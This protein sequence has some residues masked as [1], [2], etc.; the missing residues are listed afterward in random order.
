M[1]AAIPQEIRNIKHNNS[2]NLKRLQHHSCIFKIR[3]A[4]P[5]YQDLHVTLRE[6]LHW[7]LRFIQFV[8][9]GR[10]TA[11]PLVHSLLGQ[12]PNH[13]WL[14]HALHQQYN[15]MTSVLL[16]QHSSSSSHYVRFSMDPSAYPFPSH[17]ITRVGSLV[18]RF[19]G[20]WEVD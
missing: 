4:D 11:S 12:K 5:S 14:Q 1:K 2:Q 8:H 9:K 3:P 10:S 20:I 13:T 16:Y 19:P 7:V 18:W 17:R 6:T 15:K